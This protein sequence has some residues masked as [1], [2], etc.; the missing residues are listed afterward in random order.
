MLDAVITRDPILPH[1]LR[2]SIDDELETIVLKALAKERE[3]RY[4]GA[5]DLLRDIEHYLAG[6]PIDAKRDSAWY[7]LRKTL[8]RYRWP[9]A[10]A[11]GFVLV[12]VAFG[13]TL[14]E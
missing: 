6:R 10:L 12:C 4:Q 14:I 7:L 9:A 1:T 11:G 5:G 2:P 3:R 13:I 8:R